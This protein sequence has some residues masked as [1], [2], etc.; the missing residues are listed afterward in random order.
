MENKKFIPYSEIS[1]VTV[2]GK[3]TRFFRKFIPW[4]IYRF[5]VLNWKMMRI[6][7]GGHS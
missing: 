3:A 7:I 4:Q 1:F 2:P 6:V 5:V